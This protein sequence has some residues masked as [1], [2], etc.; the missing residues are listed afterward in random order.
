MKLN[1]L[2]AVCREQ[3]DTEMQVMINGEGIIG[4][5][6][7]L[8]GYLC[9]DALNMCVVEFTAVGEGSLKVWV[10]A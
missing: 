5:P 4:N 1:E 8:E 2:L 3:T 7:M 9:K 6:A 10:E